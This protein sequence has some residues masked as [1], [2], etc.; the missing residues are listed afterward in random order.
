[1]YSVKSVKDLKKYQLIAYDGEREAVDEF[2]PKA[3]DKEQYDRDF[4]CPG[5]LY[6]WRFGTRVAHETWEDY[7]V[8]YL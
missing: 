8:V 6:C 2:Y 1:M 7:P 4:G 5:T 3:V